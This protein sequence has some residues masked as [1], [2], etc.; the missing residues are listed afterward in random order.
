[1]KKIATQA[2]TC[3]LFISLLSTGMAS[4]ESTKNADPNGSEFTLDPVL[5]T[6]QRTETRELDTPATVTVLDAQ[7]LKNSG[8]RTIFDALAFTQGITNFSYGPGGQDYGAMDSRVVIRG[9]DR[10]ALVLI[11]GA[12]V[13]LLNKNSFFQ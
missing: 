8:A 12:P 7:A 1:M 2:T 4:A 13:N 9:F 5:V 6:A 10:G 11:N 3:A